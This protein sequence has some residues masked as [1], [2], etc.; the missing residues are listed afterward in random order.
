MRLPDLNKTAARLHTEGMLQ[1]PDWEKGKHVPSGLRK[2]ARQ[3]AMEL[4]PV[5]TELK[6][7]GLSLA[8]NK[9]K[10]PTPRGGRWDQSSVGTAIASRA[11]LTLVKSDD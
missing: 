3:R 1:F 9:R 5:I 2:R 6:G 4:E 10:V 8:K 7:K 11:K